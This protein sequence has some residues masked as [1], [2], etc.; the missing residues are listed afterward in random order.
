V[1]LL[2]ARPAQNQRDAARRTAD[3]VTP[4]VG[5]GTILIVDDNPVNQRVA[6]RLVER[7]GFRTEV[8]ADGKVA[9]E[10]WQAGRYAAI[11]MDCQMPKLD[12]FA[13]T[14]EIRRREGSAVHT[15]IIAM[16]AD[17]RPSTRAACH[18][19]GMDHYVSKPFSPD[20]LAAALGQFVTVE[21]RRR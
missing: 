14:A 1:P 6:A 7:M 2:E 9:L 17:A 10:R 4:A 20:E 12:G 11:L 13:A 18:A 5:A 21:V 16:T 8:A 19:A 15:P 3:P